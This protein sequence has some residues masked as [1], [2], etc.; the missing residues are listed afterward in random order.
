M[1][2][3]K[4]PVFVDLDET[5]IYAQEIEAGGG[6]RLENSRPVLDY[7]VLLRPEAPELLRH[8]RE[9]GRQ[10]FLFTHASFNFALQVSQAFSLGFDET[11]LFSFSM[12]LNC[13]RGI[14]PGSAL[15]EN[16]PPSSE[17][18]RVKMD[19][20]GIGPEQVWLLPS[21]APPRFPSARLFLL[22]LPLRL[23]RLDHFAHQAIRSAAPQGKPRSPGLPITAAEI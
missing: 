7:E 2:P 8:C 16:T 3:R 4:Q 5:L 20:L 9:G 1:H 13:R 15:V 6:P 10:V 17:M 23:A 21:Y 11:A 14:S 22:G 12:I 18:T 19:A